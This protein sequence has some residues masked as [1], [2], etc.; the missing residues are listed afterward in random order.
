M[1]KADIEFNIIERNSVMFYIQWICSHVHGIVL[2]V[3]CVH[4]CWVVCF[5]L[6]FFYC[7][8][9]AKTNKQKQQQHICYIIIKLS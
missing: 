4:V 9:I 5:M 8:S 2:Y 3:Y 6:C 7:Y 1:E